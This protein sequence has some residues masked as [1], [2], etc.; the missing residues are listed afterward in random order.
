M[1]TYIYIHTCVYIY[2]CIYNSF[3]DEWVTTKQACRDD[4]V[5][6]FSFSFQKKIYI[7]THIHI[8]TCTYIYIHIH[9]YTYIYI[10]IHTYTYLYI[11]IHTYTYIYIHIHTYTFIHTYI[12][13]CI[14]QAVL[15]A[16]SVIWD[17]SVTESWVCFVIYLMCCFRK[18]GN[19]SSE[20][21]G[22]TNVGYMVKFMPSYKDIFSCSPRC[23]S[24]FPCSLY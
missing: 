6:S 5:V 19:S 1:Y 3:P 18:F 9:T 12:H 22:G 23:V 20:T 10:H 21:R 16:F 24:F 2:I 14:E 11:H 17:L 4:L 13:I 15:K 7:Y 8:H